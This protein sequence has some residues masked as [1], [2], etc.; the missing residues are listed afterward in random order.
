MNQCEFCSRSFHN[1]KNL[2]NHSCEKKRRWYRRDDPE[3]RIAFLAWNRF[4]ELS[5]N[6]KGAKAKRSFMDFLNSSFYSGFVKFG[7]HI[8]DC[9]VINPQRFIDYVIKGNIPLDS[10]CNDTVYEQYVRDYTKTEAPEDALERMIL[11]MQQWSMQTG[12]SWNDFFRKINPNLAMQWMKSGRISP[13]VLY[14]VNSANDFLERCSPEQIGMI[15]KWAP[16]ASWR[17]KFNKNP[18]GVKFIKQTLQAAGV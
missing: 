14:N 6:Q 7:K 8:I 10:W 12:E 15:T 4:Y 3:I 16:N 1:E 17:I 9:N 18:E 13:W 11:L 5:T 2:I